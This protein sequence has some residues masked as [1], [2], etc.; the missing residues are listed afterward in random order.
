MRH[1][2]QRINWHAAPQQQLTVEDAVEDVVVAVVADA[3]TQAVAAEDINPAAKTVHP[4]IMMPAASLVPRNP[5][6][7]SA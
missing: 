5:M 3:A 6:N 1:T 4:P 7:A 2:L